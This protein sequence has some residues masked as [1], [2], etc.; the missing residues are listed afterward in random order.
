MLVKLPTLVP[1]NLAKFKFG[2]IEIVLLSIPLN[3]CILT[4]LKV[5][6]VAIVSDSITN[7][8]PIF[9]L[10]TL[11]TVIVLALAS[12][13]KVKNVFLVFSRPQKHAEFVS[14]KL[15]GL[16]L[17]IIPLAPADTPD[18]A[19]VA[20]TADTGSVTVPQ[21]QKLPLASTQ[22]VPNAVNAVFTVLDALNLP[23]LNIIEALST[24]CIVV[25]KLFPFPPFPNIPEVLY[26]IVWPS[27]IINLSLAPD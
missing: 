18:I 8:S 23:P 9:Q 10:Y 3:P 16:P 15:V 5:L 6:V 12:A 26:V 19:I 21:S 13:D 27:L 24:F 7:S 20:V 14:V 25:P 11:S 4:P 22:I 17:T 1:D 2:L